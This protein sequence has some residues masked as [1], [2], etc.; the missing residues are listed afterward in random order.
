M[1]DAQHFQLLTKNR[2]G[3]IQIELVLGDGM[4]RRASVS[5]RGAKRLENVV[6]EKRRRQ[7]PPGV[8]ECGAAG[9]DTEI[10][11]YIHTCR[12]SQRRF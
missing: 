9:R 7:W 2:D 8:K 12:A 1:E 6:S 3:L 11:R 5:Q 4:C 10:D